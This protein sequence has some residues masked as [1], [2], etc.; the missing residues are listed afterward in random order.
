M[1]YHFLRPIQNPMKSGDVAILTD[2]VAMEN[3]CIKG[4]V[5][6]NGQVLELEWD[7]SGQVKNQNDSFNLLTH[8]ENFRDVED[9]LNCIIN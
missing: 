6:N 5:Y 2:I 1:K 3:G 4:S 9:Y 7:R 8:S